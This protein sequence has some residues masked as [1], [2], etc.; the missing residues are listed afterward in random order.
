[1]IQDWKEDECQTEIIL[2]NN[3][4]GQLQTINRFKTVGTRSKQKGE[5]MSRTDV[6]LE[7]VL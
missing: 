4:P 6:E 1:M 2:A 7:H 3:I 5:E